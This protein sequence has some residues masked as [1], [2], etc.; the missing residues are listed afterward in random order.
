MKIR[1]VA[2]CLLLI[3]MT[4]VAIAC[5]RKGTDSPHPQKDIRQEVY[6]IMKDWYLFYDKVPNVN[7]LEFADTAIVD[8]L[9][10]KAADH[11]SFILRD[12]GKLVEELETGTQQGS[13][14]A[15]IVS[16]GS[17]SRVIAVIPGSPAAQIGLA[18][19]DSVVFVQATQSH[20]TLRWFDAQ[21]QEKTG[22][23]FWAKV[24]VNPVLHTQVFDTLAARIGYWVFLEF[25]DTNKINLIENSF[26]YFQQQN[27]S[28]LIVDLRYN[29]G[30]YLRTMEM[31]ANLLAP[32]SANGKLMY[33]SML[34]DRYPKERE[35]IYFRLS[36]AGLPNLTEIIFITSSETAS[37]SDMLINSLK[38]YIKITTVG[39]TSVGKYLG[40]PIFEYLGYT[41]AIVSSKSVNAQGDPKNFEGITGWQPSIVATDGIAFPWGDV[42]DDM[43]R[44][45]FAA[46]SGTSTARQSAVHPAEKPYNFLFRSLGDKGI[47]LLNP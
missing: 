11:W 3:S 25:T 41:L 37:S 19:G 5:Q 35:D 32:A 29:G 31:V 47:I 9:K 23:A 39:Q 10:Y 46:I 33:S 20:V 44:A 38:P 17:Y 27:V 1:A 12:D 8:A 30:G 42:R 40:Y 6:K 43:L 14:G 45:A 15:Y 36:P 26:R 18:R 7:P 13:I 16:Q 34:N 21:K 22:T 28:K 24:S 2:K 4:W